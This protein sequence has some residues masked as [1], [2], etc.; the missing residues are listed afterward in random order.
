MNIKLDTIVKKEGSKVN[1]PEPS[2][3]GYFRGSIRCEEGIPFAVSRSKRV[4]I[5][6]GY[7]IG[8]LYRDKIDFRYYYVI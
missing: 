7:R 8:L 5:E 2:G 1:C 4:E 3:D 6:R